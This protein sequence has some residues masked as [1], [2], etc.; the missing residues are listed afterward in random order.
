MS[1]QLTHTH[2]HTAAVVT[3]LAS[4]YQFKEPQGAIGIALRRSGYTA[5]VIRV[6][7]VLIEGSATSPFDFLIP[8]RPQVVTFNAG[9]TNACEQ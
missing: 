2:T 6:N 5:G 8:P 7:C 1:F 3:F 9:D 4:E